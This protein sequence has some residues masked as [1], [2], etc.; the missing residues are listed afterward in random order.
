MGALAAAGIPESLM[1]DLLVASGMASA[2]VE[3]FCFGL[4]GIAE[5]GMTKCEGLSSMGCGPGKTDG[6]IAFGALAKLRDASKTSM[7]GRASWY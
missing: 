5:C 1:P 4:G 2:D 7:C 6:I 3:G